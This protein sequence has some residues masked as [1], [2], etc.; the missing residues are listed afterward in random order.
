MPK[1]LKERAIRSHMHPA[2]GWF[3]RE[4]VEGVIPTT[5]GHTPVAAWT[6]DGRAVVTLADR[7][8]AQ[9]GR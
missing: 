5:L 2:A 1:P 3:M 6:K 9:T 7:A 8:G 4:Q